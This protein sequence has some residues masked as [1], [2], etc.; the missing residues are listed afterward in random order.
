MTIRLAPSVLQDIEIPE[1]VEY[2]ADGALVHTLTQ[3]LSELPAPFNSADLWVSCREAWPHNDPDFAGTM[4]ISLVIQG[5][6]RYSQLGEGSVVETIE[7]RPGCLFPTNPLALH[8]LEP[9]DPDLGF[10]ALQWEVPYH[11]YEDRMKD[12]ADRIGGMDAH[13]KLDV[14]SQHGLIPIDH[15]AYEYKP[16]G[17][18]LLS[19]AQL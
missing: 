16:P 13:E 6:H 12:L 4:F 17:F 7:V 3:G 15:D 18:P 10:I 14:A 2:G 5:A 8:W 19:S 11:E 1:S 9:L